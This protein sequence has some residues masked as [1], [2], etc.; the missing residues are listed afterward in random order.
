MTAP[1]VPGELI[2]V[3]DE[4]ALA[5]I[6]AERFVT[7]SAAAIAARGRFDVALAGGATPKAAYALL[8]GNAFRGRVDWGKVRFFFSDE[9]CVPPDDAES[10]YKTAHDAMLAPLGIA[11]ASVFRMHGEDEP[12]SAAAAYV[13]VLRTHLSSRAEPPEGAQSRDEGPPQLDLV[14]LGMGPDAHTAS[15]F[16]GSDPF[17]DD[18]ALVRAPFVPKFDTHRLTF[19]PRTI[20]AARIVQIATAGP[21]KADALALVR[22]GPYD[23][24]KLPIQ[25]VAPVEGTLVW[26]VDREAAAKLTTTD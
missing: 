16:P 14:M 21:T 7:Q 6:V 22:E 5:R 23:P 2:V 24:V 13:E 4:N 25:S 19:T 8:A 15:L 20:N 17:E 3:D 18:D 10:N 9:R 1:R 26:L 11:P 12:V